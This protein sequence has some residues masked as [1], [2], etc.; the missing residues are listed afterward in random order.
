VIQQGAERSRP[1]VALA[2]SPGEAQAAETR[3]GGARHKIARIAWK[4]MTTAKVTMASDARRSAA[5]A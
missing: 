5:D 3:A 1:S 2:G 4:L